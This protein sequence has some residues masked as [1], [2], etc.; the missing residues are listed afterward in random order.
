MAKLEASCPLAAITNSRIVA[1][2]EDASGL[3]ADYYGV[4]QKIIE[5][6]FSGTKELKV[7]S[8]SM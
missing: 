3:A 7:V 1:N 5:Y 4:L 2:G 8:F 6:T